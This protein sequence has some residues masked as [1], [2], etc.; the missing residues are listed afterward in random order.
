MTMT[1]YPA[2]IYVGEQTAKAVYLDSSRVWCIRRAATAALSG[3][4]A[5][6][7]TALQQL[8]SSLDLSGGG[9]LSA[10]TDLRHLISSG[11]SADGTLLAPITQRHDMPAAFSGGG[12]LSATAVPAAWTPLELTGLDAWID[13]AQDKALGTFSDGQAITTYTSHD[14]S[15]RV[16]TAYADDFASAGSHKP[17]YRA[18]SVGGKPRLEFNIAA[19]GT[20]NGTYSPG[21]TGLTF[22]TVLRASQPGWYG[23]HWSYYSEVPNYDYEMRF[24]NG[25]MTIQAVADYGRTGAAPVSSFSLVGDVDYI[26]MMRV[27]IPNRSVKLWIND[28]LQFDITSADVIASAGD[29]SI[30]ARRWSDGLY[31]YQTL[32]AEALMISGPISDA[33]RAKLVSYLRDKHGA[34]PGV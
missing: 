25:N 16:F 23:M 5:L 32:V 15:G 29:L 8:L 34:L 6:S 13:P 18:S 30:G 31:L 1:P 7:A 3:G 14:P 11:L 20:G 4:T 12:T 19:M 26:V 24:N 21:P 10:T 27:D 2:D 33:D 28:T 17:I 22:V 9:A